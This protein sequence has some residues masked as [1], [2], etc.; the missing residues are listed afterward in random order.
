MRY[1]ISTLL[2]SSRH[3]R[4]HRPPELFGGDGKP[5]LAEEEYMALAGIWR[6]DLELDDGD[7][8]I[9][10]HL[11]VP[12]FQIG[13]EVPDG[14]FGKVYLMNDTPLRPWSNIC[15][16]GSSAARWSAYRLVRA[17][18]EGDHEM[19]LQLQLGNLYLEGRGVRDGFRCS[20]FEGTV[21]EGGEDPYVV[22]RFSMRLSFSL[23]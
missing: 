14:A 4:L 18:A 13:T 20:S 17:G 22:G 7:D 1:L 2:A 15:D 8:M 23:L 3:V 16:K 9:S 12:K 10:M 5:Q 6:A 19:Q 21:L 11:A